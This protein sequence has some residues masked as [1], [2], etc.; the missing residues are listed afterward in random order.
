MPACLHASFGGT[1]LT[2]LHNYFVEVVGEVQGKFRGSL[3]E[4]QGKFRGVSAK[5][6][7]N[8]RCV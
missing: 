1:Q 6:Q 7:I 2:D 4:V 3:R 5:Y 8:Y